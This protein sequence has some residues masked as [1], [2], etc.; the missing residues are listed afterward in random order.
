MR[1]LGGLPEVPCAKCG[2]HVPG[3]SW[4]EYCPPCREGRRKRAD[5]IARRISG[6]VG[7]LTAVWVF[8]ELPVTVTARVWGAGIVVATWFLARQIATRLLMEFLPK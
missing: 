4:G 1:S 7:A 6:V 8:I 3:L 5:R 2:Q